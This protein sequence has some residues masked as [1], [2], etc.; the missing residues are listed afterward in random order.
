MNSITINASPAHVA[1]VIKIDTATS[2][3]VNL[4][5][6]ATVRRVRSD[7]ELAADMKSP[8]DPGLTR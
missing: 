3:L 5:C 1:V 8:Y 6:G 2:Y 7:V 4:M